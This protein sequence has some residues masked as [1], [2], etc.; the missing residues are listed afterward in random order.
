MSLA[1]PRGQF[2]CGTRSTAKLEAA[3]RSIDM[4]TIGAR[5][6]ISIYR[7]LALYAS[8]LFVPWN[9]MK[10]R[11]SESERAS[12]RLARYIKLRDL[13]KS[14][15]LR[16]TEFE[17]QAEKIRLKSRSEQKASRRAQEEEFFRKLRMERHK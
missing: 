8:A 12:G 6:V 3:S 15:R 13:A 5:N 11:K 16:A 14:Y 2:Q 7:Y 17:I 4:R 1:M 10:R 9:L